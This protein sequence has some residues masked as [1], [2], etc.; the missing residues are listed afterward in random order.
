MLLFYQCTVYGYVNSVSFR[1]K[2]IISF[3][4]YAQ[5]PELLTVQSG[6]SCSIYTS[7]I[8]AESFNSD[9]S[10]VCDDSTISLVCGNYLLMQ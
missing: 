9:L 5:I 10:D 4:L 8:F 2:H 7:Y 1:L 3:R 6:F